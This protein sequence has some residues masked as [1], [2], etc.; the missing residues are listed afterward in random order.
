MGSSYNMQAGPVHRVAHQKLLCLQTIAMHACAQGTHKWVEIHTHSTS[1][2]PS[3]V[4]VPA[5]AQLLATAG[6]SKA[7]PP[8]L[9]TTCSAKAIMYTVLSSSIH[10]Q[11][12]GHTR[13]TMPCN[14]LH[15]FH[16]LNCSTDLVIVPNSQGPGIR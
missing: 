14:K 15:A 12:S 1:H 5:R 2:H 6:S 3:H 7:L 9:C 16:H 8:R 13:L 4:P 11:R 10:L